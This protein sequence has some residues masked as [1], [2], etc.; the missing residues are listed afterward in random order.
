VPSFTQF[1]ATLDLWARFEGLE[2]V[3]AGGH[4]ALTFDD[5]PDPE[6]TPAV[7][8]ALDVTGLKATFF[9]VGEQLMANPR[10]GG[11]LVRRGHEVELHGFAHVRH[12]DL[13]AREAR[14]DLA[15]GLGAVE[16]AT[17]RRPRFHRPP[18]GEF[19]A[20]SHAACADLGLEPV[21]WSSWGMDWETIGAERIADLVARDLEDGAIVVLHDSAR[22]AYRETAV[23]TAEAIPLIAAA[24]E[25]RGLRLVPLGEA[26]GGG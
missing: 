2:Q 12:P 25:E 13:S 3:P 23:P 7:L 19:S 9:L 18:Y 4:A 17:G 6:G 11:E 8:D 14:D 1:R 24:A 16:A 22:Y 15:R 21:L 20:D 26:A 10:L 5:G